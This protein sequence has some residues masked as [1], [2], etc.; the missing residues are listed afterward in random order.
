MNTR[1]MAPLE[2]GPKAKAAALKALELD[3]SLP[4]AHASL[5]KVY[6]YYDWDWAGA[7]KEFLRSLELNPNLPEAHLGYADYLASVGRFDESI[8]HARFA[9][10]LDPLSVHAR[11]QA[12]A[13]PFGA[14]R[15]YEETLEECRKVR[16]LPPDFTEP[17]DDEAFAYARLGRFQE[18]TQAAANAVRNNNS[19]LEI[20]KAAVVYAES[21]NKEE[22]RRLLQ[23]LVAA[24]EKQFVCGYNVATVYAALG[25]KDQAFRWLEEGIKQRTL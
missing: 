11:F 1:Y 5:G 2:A 18:A 6:L 19:P 13:H 9:F 3:D 8:Q 12:I 4:L 22:A 14:S 16:E 20:A 10:A 21:G 15:R 7:E 17:F 24:A 23:G 25:E